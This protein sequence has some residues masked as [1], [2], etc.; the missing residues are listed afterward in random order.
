MKYSLLFFILNEKLESI[1]ID[2]VNFDYC[3]K[4]DK[5]IIYIYRGGTNEGY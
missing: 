4:E 2:K 3:N 1:F 5:Y